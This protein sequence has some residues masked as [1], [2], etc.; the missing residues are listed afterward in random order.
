M[1]NGA[2]GATGLT[3]LGDLMV[4]RYLGDSAEE[5]RAVL[6][7]WWTIVRPSLAGCPAVRP[8]IWST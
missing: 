2:E 8:R 5:A 4:G 6:A 3:L 1:D 7:A